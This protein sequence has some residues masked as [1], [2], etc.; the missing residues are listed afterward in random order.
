[1]LKQP[2]AFQPVVPLKMKEKGEKVK[3]KNPAEH[4]HK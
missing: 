2:I 3:K 4:K 1:M